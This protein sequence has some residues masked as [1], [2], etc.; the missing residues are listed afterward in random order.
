MLRTCLNPYVI[1]TWNRIFLLLS[2]SLDCRE[3][4]VLISEKNL[5]DTD[6][7]RLK[8]TS[9]K[10]SVFIIALIYEYIRSSLLL[11]SRSSYQFH[12]MRWT[13]LK[14]YLLSICS[15]LLN[16]SYYGWTKNKTKKSKQLHVNNHRTWKAGLAFTRQIHEKLKIT[17]LHRL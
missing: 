9:L 1:L 11:T 17:S 10:L 6:L 13:C 5:S 14:C 16:H 12:Y 8:K 7:S 15:F 3:F 4:A 2:V